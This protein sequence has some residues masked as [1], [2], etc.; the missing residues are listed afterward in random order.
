M[1]QSRN[2][3]NWDLNNI[4]KDSEYERVNFSRAQPV[5]SGGG[6]MIGVRLFPGDDT[7]RTFRNCNLTNCEVPPGS[8]VINC[9]STIIERDV[10]DYTDEIII[11][12][13]TVHSVV[14]TKTIIHGSWDQ[15]TLNYNYHPTPVEISNG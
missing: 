10:Y 1:I 3:S 2:F 15:S 14:H 6:V 11:D 9:N 13:N 5:D 7:P 8:T 4:P 12:G